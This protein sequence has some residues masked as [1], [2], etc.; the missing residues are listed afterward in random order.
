[1][2]WNPSN[3]ISLNISSKDSV[4]GV[5][6]WLIW[7]SVWLW[8][9]SWCYGSWVW[10]PHW[11]LSCQLRVCLGFC[12]PLSMSLPCSL[13]LSQVN[14]P[15]KKKVC[16]CGCVCVCVCLDLKTEQISVICACVLSIS[17]IVV[18]QNDLMSTWKRVG[19]WSRDWTGLLGENRI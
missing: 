19:W 16:V 8:L 10:A 7:L 13:S 14:K 4:W 9:R 18:L 2:N 6:G 15:L 11:A 3:V 5:P 17:I 1:M 12:L